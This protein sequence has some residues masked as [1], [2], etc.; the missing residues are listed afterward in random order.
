MTVQGRPFL[1]GDKRQD[2]KNGKAVIM[3]AVE[4]KESVTAIKNSTCKLLEGSM[5]KKGRLQGS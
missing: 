5:L 3:Q 2:K 1:G 4:G